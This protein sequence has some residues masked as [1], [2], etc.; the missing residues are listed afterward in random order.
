LPASQPPTSAP[1]ALTLW[2]SMTPADGLASRP[3]LSRS[4]ITAMSWIVSKRNRRTKRRNHQY[5][6]PEGGKSFGNMRHPAPERAM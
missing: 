3:T 5:T 2:L 4:I 6:V 1:G